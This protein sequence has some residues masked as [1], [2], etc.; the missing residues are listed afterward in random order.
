M[1][2]AGLNPVLMIESDNFGG[3]IRWHAARGRRPIV[4][5]NREW[6]SAR[7]GAPQALIKIDE[8]NGVNGNQ[9]QTCNGTMNMAPEL[10]SVYDV[11]LKK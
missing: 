1:M 8:K 3:K 5:E 7:S 9:E 11:G 4:R 2:D 10:M 6:I